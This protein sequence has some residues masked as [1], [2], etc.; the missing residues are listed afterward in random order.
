MNR[1]AHQDQFTEADEDVMWSTCLFGVGAVVVLLVGSLAYKQISDNW[2]VIKMVLMLQIP[3]LLLYLYDQGYMKFSPGR[4][5]N[6]QQRSGSYW[7]S[8]RRY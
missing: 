3:L 4:N 6:H 2:Q 5:S 8:S 1:E 7:Q